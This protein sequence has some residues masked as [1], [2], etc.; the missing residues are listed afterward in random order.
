MTSLR[1]ADR[2]VLPAALLLAAWLSGCSPRAVVIHT[3][4]DAF[5]STGESFATDGDPELVREAAPFALKA[6]E[7]FLAETP[8]NRGL[9]TALSGGFTQYAA[10]F[11][12][13]DAVE[14]PDPESAEAGKDRARRLYLRARDYGLRGLEAAHPGFREALA[15]DPAEALSQAGP[16]DVSLLYWTAASWT[17]AIASSGMAPALLADLPLCEALMRRALSLDEGFGAGAIHEYFIAYEGGRPEAMGSSVE[18]ARFHLE[19]AMAFAEGKRVSPLVT[20]AETV[21]VRTQDKTEFLAL[22]DRALAF[23]ALREAPEF[24]LANLVA[25]RRARWLKERAD[26]LFLD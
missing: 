1:P 20:M 6:M 8:E 11:V 15:K 22:L 19:R 12:W 25:Q 21:S 13:Q 2:L 10:A 18:R 4:A 14:S 5:A 7:S 9:L 23:D 17:L 16:A 26:E 24:R 3:A